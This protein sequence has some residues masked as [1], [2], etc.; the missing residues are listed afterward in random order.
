MV[1]KG[2][3]PPDAFEA[4]TLFEM[5]NADKQD[6]S[7][8]AIV[9]AKGGTFVYLAHLHSSRY[10]RVREA[11]A[12]AD[13]H[14]GSET[15][16][17]RSLESMGG[18]TPA[19]AEG[20]ME[21]ELV[22]LETL[23][24]RDAFRVK[25][26]SRTD[27]QNLYNAQKM[28]RVLMTFYAT[29]KKSTSLGGG[30]GQWF[31]DMGLAGGGVVRSSGAGDPEVQP[32]PDE[33]Q[34]RPVMAAL[35]YLIRFVLG[36]SYSARLSND[37]VIDLPNT[38]DRA[39]QILLREQYVIEWL[40][41]VISVAWTDENLFKADATLVADAHRFSTGD[42]RLADVG[43][44]EA[45]RKVAEL[46]PLFQVLRLAHN[47]LKRVLTANPRCCAVVDKLD[48]SEMLLAQF[49]TAWEPPVTEYFA[50]LLAPD[51]IGRGGDGAADGAG[52]GGE[53]ETKLWKSDLFLLVD[54]IHGSLNEALT[55]EKA[56]ADAS[57]G[58]PGP[59]SGASRW[60]ETAQL[61]YES[62][63]KALDFLASVC[64]TGGVANERLQVWVTQLLVGLES[65]DNE[66]HASS[67]V[68]HLR[69][70]AARDDAAPCGYSGWRVQISTE[71]EHRKRP[72]Y[73]PDPEEVEGEIEAWNEAHPNEPVSSSDP[74]K[75]PNDTTEGQ[76]VRKRVIPND[77]EDDH[78]TCMD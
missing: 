73:Q 57:I 53:Q 47:L 40:L 49:K 15:G 7:D 51:A 69:L 2:E 19:E 68:M 62:V 34:C 9:F 66:P 21:L 55:A 71:R 63:A 64:N 12:A 43:A 58:S 3:L 61:H 42:K 76:K 70:L 36:A 30:G 25:P 77:F 44:A 54:Q 45:D 52:G 17:S 48:V 59:N 38:P 74:E 67:L 6:S 32:P 8:S 1:R 13:E 56:A 72:P 46:A 35:K 31:A 18:D 14:D 5:I 75:I 65:D 22:T 37:E 16:F 28:L 27:I 50:A 39:H 29:L 41:G 24:D 33:R 60:L 20:E 10:L 11:Q 4:G 78:K 23:S 26:A